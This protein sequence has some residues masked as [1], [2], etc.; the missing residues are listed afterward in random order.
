MLDDGNDN[1]GEE[2]SEN[3]GWMQSPPSSKRG[4]VH[5]SPEQRK[6]LDKLNFLDKFYEIESQ[7]NSTELSMP[8][9]PFKAMSSH[10]SFITWRSIL[11]KGKAQFKLKRKLDVDQEDPYQ[12]H[13]KP[14]VAEINTF[15][16]PAFAD[17]TRSERMLLLLHDIFCMS[18]EYCDV[19]YTLAEY[20]TLRL[21]RCQLF[22][23]AAS[24]FI[25]I[26]LLY[27][28]SDHPRKNQVSIAAGTLGAVV[29]TVLSWTKFANYDSLATS[30]TIA[31]GRFYRIC[32][33]TEIL[34]L[35]LKQSIAVV[36]RDV[37]LDTLD[38]I[39]E[40]EYAGDED[41]EKR[42]IDYKNK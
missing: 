28:D 24:A 31:Y 39:L 6:K 26:I 16:L 18:A 10:H 34:F 14:L 1:K 9:I 32:S 37:V 2:K 21:R 19:H 8:S 5:M 40:A 41:K 30:H 22:C 12:L 23:L 38:S 11:R 3:E 33:S 27:F 17:T 4:C 13:V 42:A 29:A 7:F 35:Q 25:T 15:K 36:D 20:Y